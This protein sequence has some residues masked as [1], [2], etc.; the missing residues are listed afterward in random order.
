[1]SAKRKCIQC[2]QIRNCRRNDKVCYSC[3]SLNAK[4]ARGEAMEPD[5]P[6]VT[7]ESYKQPMEQVKNGYGY[8]GALTETRDGEFVQCH[9][10]GYYFSNVGTHVRAK[11]KMAPKD[12]KIK[13]GLR[14]KD[15]LLSQMAKE[16]AQDIYNKYARKTPEQ[17]KAMS[18]KAHV[19]LRKKGYEGGHGWSAI[20]RNERGMCRE[21]T[22]AKIKSLGET[23]NGVPTE[24]AFLAMYGSGQKDVLKHWFGGWRQAVEAAGLIHYGITSNLKDRKLREG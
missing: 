12:Y 1:M 7:V 2:K 9:I 17:F 19:V 16:K 15:G 4:V 20:T 5:Y 23:M 6:D 11:H 24:T 21:Q 8:Y 14:I 13:F 10:C 22:L 18:H 3:Q